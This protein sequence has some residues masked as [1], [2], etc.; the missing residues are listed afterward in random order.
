M[1]YWNRRAEFPFLGLG[2]GVLLRI[3]KGGSSTDHVRWG[4]SG[5]SSRTGMVGWADKGLWWWK[6]ERGEGMETVVKEIARKALCFE[7]ARLRWSKGL[8]NGGPPDQTDEVVVEGFVALVWVG[9][10][11]GRNRRV[12]SFLPFPVSLDITPIGPPHALSSSHL[13]CLIS[14]LGQALPLV[15]LG[16]K[17]KSVTARV[18]TP[19]DPD[20][21]HFASLPLQD[22]DLVPANAQQLIISPFYGCA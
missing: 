7:R 21:G 16:D 15:P 3:I 6:R 10:A 1:G 12:P 18:R 14:R 11:G 9:G 17:S 13:S 19:R 20:L 5:V 22:H 8:Y 2:L 4:L